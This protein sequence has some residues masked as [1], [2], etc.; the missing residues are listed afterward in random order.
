M[1][2]KKA[3]YKKKPNADGTPAR[4]EKP[5]N[6][7]RRALE[8]VARYLVNLNATEAYKAVFE[9]EK[10]KLDDHSARTGASR[11]LQRDD[12]K[13]YVQEAIKERNAAFQ[14]DAYYVV[15]R[16]HAIV[17]TDYTEAVQ[18][19]TQD[20]INQIPTSVR[21]LI[22]SIDIEKTKTDYDGEYSKSVETQRYKV[23]FMSKDKA[24]ESLAKHTGV[25]I[26][27]NIQLQK[28]VSKMSFTEIM[29]EI[30]GE[31]END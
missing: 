10:K 28:D 24:L 29:K 3:R 9:T 23:T 31:L 16:L 20:E 27:D 14:V 17:E 5:A 12:I 1:E 21:K 2:R 8:F 11:L 18:Y 6:A 4:K 13:Q 22:Q 30:E 7:D 15:Q 19:L 26:K 25:F